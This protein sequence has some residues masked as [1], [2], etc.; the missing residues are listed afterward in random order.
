VVEG[1]EES[2]RGMRVGGRREL[3]VPSKLA[4]GTGTLI[5]VIDLLKV[6]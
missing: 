4:Y 5:Y 3:I 6:E 1:W 2:L